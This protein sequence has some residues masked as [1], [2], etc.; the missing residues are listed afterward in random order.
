ML[1]GSISRELA[2]DTQVLDMPAVTRICEIPRC[3]EC[4]S[5]QRDRVRGRLRRCGSPQC[6]REDVRQLRPAYTPSRRAMTHPIGGGLDR[7]RA[8]VVDM[9]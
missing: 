4:P 9:P 8:W 2:R 7:G 6:H 3:S 1:H 5:K